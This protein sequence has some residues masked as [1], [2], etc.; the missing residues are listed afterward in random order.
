MKWESSGNFMRRLCGRAMAFVGMAFAAISLS[1]AQAE[2]KQERA[3]LDSW[4]AAEGW[5]EVA[6]VKLEPADGSR[7]VSTPGTGVLLSPGGKVPFLVSKEPHGDAE[8]HVEFNIPAHSNSGVYVMGSYEVQIYDSHGVEKDKYPG[9]EC[10]G[11][12]PEWI[13]NANVRGHSPRVN[14]ALPAG[15]WQSFDI[16][17]RAP[18]FDAQGRKTANARFEKVVHNGKL[19]Q[20]NVEVLGPTHGGM[21]ESSTGKGCLML[22]GDHGVVAYRNVRVKVLVAHP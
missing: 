10:G 14:A 16:V 3:G 5:S 6:A 22:Q 7:F 4:Q 17:F 2:E 13:G 21:E 8:I 15:E 12:Y 9:I 18:R 1:M 19:V 11:I 20:E